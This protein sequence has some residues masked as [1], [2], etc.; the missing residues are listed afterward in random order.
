MSSIA[1]TISPKVFSTNTTAAAILCGSIKKTPVPKSTL[2]P[3]VKQVGQ[4]IQVYSHPSVN[5]EPK[6]PLKKYHIENVALMAF[7]T[8]HLYF[9]TL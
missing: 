4:L 8:Y 1:L 5:T 7:R 9:S 2:N 6:V 3:E